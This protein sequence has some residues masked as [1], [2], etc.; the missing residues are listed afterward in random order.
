MSNILL[1]GG[2]HCPGGYSE[3]LADEHGSASACA[4]NRTHL[5]PFHSRLPS[6][7]AYFAP[8]AVWKLH[9]LK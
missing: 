5:S 2:S 3:V 7:Q 4:H 8:E 9:V 6:P 1:R